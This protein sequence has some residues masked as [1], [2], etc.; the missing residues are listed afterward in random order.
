MSDVEVIRLPR[1][2]EQE[3]TSPLS[4]FTNQGKFR[5][6]QFRDKHIL[7]PVRF[8]PCEKLRFKIYGFQ[9]SYEYGEIFW[10][11]RFFF[12][13]T[14]ATINKPSQLD[15]TTF[16]MILTIHIFT[17]SINITEQNNLIATRIAYTLATDRIDLATSMNEFSSISWGVFYD[18][19]LDRHTHRQHHYKLENSCILYEYFIGKKYI[20][21]AG[22]STTC[23]FFNRSFWN[24]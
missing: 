19:R 10:G 24:L 12:I 1:V 14:E 3:I 16:S 11:G 18:W 17:M 22:R 21:L 8:Q 23:S 15:R 4:D 5:V 20:C 6:S 13:V 2:S 7:W 9:D